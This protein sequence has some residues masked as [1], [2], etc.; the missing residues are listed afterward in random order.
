[1]AK[2]RIIKTKAVAQVRFLYPHFHRYILEKKSFWGWKKIDELH[3]E[4][5]YE[6]TTE[7]LKN[8]PPS[9]IIATFKK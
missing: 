5:N 8:I 6:A 2:Y 7:F 3:A 1:M 4:Y 9:K